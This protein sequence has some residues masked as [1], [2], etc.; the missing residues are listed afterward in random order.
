MRTILHIRTWPD[1]DLSH[2]LIDRQRTLPDTTIEI[3]DLT[4]NNL[5]Y[6][7]LVEKIFTAD[8]VEVW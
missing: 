2:V 1:E 3:V 6:E 4:Q 7:A 8:S 5:D